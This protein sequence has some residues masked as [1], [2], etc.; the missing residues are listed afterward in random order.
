M[1]A[2]VFSEDFLLA[3][4]VAAPIVAL[5]G[6][7]VV[8][9]ARRGIM[10]R[11]RASLFDDGARSLARLAVLWLVGYLAFFSM[12]AKVF[13]F[14]FLLVVPPMAIAT[15]FAADR[16]IRELI[17][18]VRARDGAGRRSCALVVVC[19]IVGFS[20]AFAARRPIQKALAPNY[21]RSSDRPMKWSDAPVPWFV[22]RFFRWC[23][24]E[25]I[26]KAHVD[27]G[28]ITESLFTSRYSR[29]ERAGHDRTA[30]TGDLRRIPELLSRCSPVAAS[31]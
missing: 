24:F 18:L 5:I 2:Q 26:A 12:L 13:P 25:D 19:I 27:Y 21:E 31:H 17:S 10:V 16:M 7:D 23:C 20:A 14:Y 29:E 11:L 4:T 1:S 3:A 30:R 15:G 8:P 28:T 6:S 22:N 9:V